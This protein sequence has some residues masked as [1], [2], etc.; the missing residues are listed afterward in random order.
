METQYAL[1][2]AGDDPERSSH[3]FWF[4]RRLVGIEEADLSD[5]S[6]PVYLDVTS[7]RTGTPILDTAKTTHLEQL[8]E[9]YTSQVKYGDLFNRTEEM[10]L[11]LFWTVGLANA[12]YGKH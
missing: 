2:H 5:H 3:Y 9:L 1:A 6:A 4:N 11:S 12:I 10:F 8:R 7:R